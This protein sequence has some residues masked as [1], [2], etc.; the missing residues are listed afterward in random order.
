MKMRLKSTVLCYE[1]P[2]ST[3]ILEFS[4]FIINQTFFS[5]ICSCRYSLQHGFGLESDS[6]T[7]KILRQQYILQTMA[8]G[9]YLDID[10]AQRMTQRKYI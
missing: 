9:D 2:N 8:Q 1:S 5:D 4:I 10:R 7:A 3:I 6:K